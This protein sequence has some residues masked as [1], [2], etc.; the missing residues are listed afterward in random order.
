MMHQGCYSLVETEPTPTDP[1]GWPRFR[2]VLRWEDE[3]QPILAGGYGLEETGWELIFTAS[4][5]SSDWEQ[6]LGPSS[7]FD[8]ETSQ[9]PE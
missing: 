3:A 9:E 1:I 4:D 6:L 2:F 5:D 7:P 8:G